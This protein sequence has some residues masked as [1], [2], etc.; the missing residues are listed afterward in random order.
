MG[1]SGWSCFNRA[2]AAFCL[3]S[4]L[5]LPIAYTH[6]HT[7]THTYIH[8]TYKREKQRSVKSRRTQKK[9]K[10]KKNFCC[11]KSQICTVTRMASRVASTLN[12]R[13]CGDAFCFPL[14]LPRLRLRLLSSWRVTSSAT[15]SKVAC[16][17]CGWDFF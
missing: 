8:A 1:I 17:L 7:H 2:C 15:K 10:K 16:D 9:K 13:S 4:R 5:F 12:E 14:P 3:A 6:T 11:S